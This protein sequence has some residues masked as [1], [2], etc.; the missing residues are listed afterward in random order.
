[1][2]AAPVTDFEQLKTYP[3]VALLV[4]WNPQAV[5]GAKFDRNELSITLERTRIR[6]ACSLLKT[7]S[8]LKFE[9]LCDVT[10]VDWY[11]AEPRFEEVYHLLS[12]CQ[13]KRL[14]LKTRLPGDDPS[15]ESV[16]DVHP[17][18]NL[19]EREI[20]DLFGVRFLGHPNLIRLMMPEAWK[21]HPLRKDYP[22]EGY[23]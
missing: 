6:E 21:G 11:P 10:C 15:L 16:T 22:V 2:I 12:I 8:Q 23:R 14:R 4:G 18:A 13:K 19:Y 3:A 20:F 7:D 9:L 5:V 1:M 17:G